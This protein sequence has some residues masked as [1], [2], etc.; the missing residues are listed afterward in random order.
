MQ[1]YVLRWLRAVGATSALAALFAVAAVAATGGGSTP[2][3]TTS[4]TGLPALDPG[5]SAPVLRPGAKPIIDESSE[6][7]EILARDDA[8]ISGITAGDQKLTG[9]LAGHLRALAAKQAQARKHVKPPA[10]PASFSGDWTASGPNPIG[11]PT[12]SSGAIAAMSGRIGALAIRPSN[13]QYILGAAQGG[14]W[15]YDTAT[16][17]WEPKTDNMPSLAIGALAIAPSD[18]SIV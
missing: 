13:G 7:E 18:D 14:I 16:S 1:K 11:Q 4:T 3:P 9:Q 2:P 17:T 5:L 10:G 8:F 15:L 6:E 12:R